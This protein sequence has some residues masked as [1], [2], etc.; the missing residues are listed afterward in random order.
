[1]GEYGR[2]SDAR[3]LC[4]PL[5]ICIALFDVLEWMVFPQQTGMSWLTAYANHSRHLV[6]MLLTIVSQSKQGRNIVTV[7]CLHFGVA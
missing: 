5:K 7:D 3:T 6:H 4:H 1:M 2:R